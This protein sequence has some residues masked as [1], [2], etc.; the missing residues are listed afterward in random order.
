MKD[1][2]WS[3]LFRELK[4]IWK[5]TS[6]NVPDGTCKPTETFTLNITSEMLVAPLY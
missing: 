1:N 6:S 2:V 4:Y 5:S 3:T